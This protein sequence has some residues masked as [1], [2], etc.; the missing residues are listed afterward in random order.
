MMGSRILLF[1]P[2]IEAFISQECFLPAE[3]GLTGQVSFLEDCQNVSLFEDL[4]WPATYSQKLGIHP[5][6]CCPT[7]LPSEEENVTFANYDFEY[8]QESLV[9][10]SIPTMAD[11]NCSPYGEF[12][13]LPGIGNF[14]ECVSFHHCGK[15]I[16]SVDFP[17]SILTCGF[18]DST[19]NMMICCPKEYVSD[20]QQNKQKPRFPSASRARNC[21]DKHDLCEKW[22]ENGG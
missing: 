16:D 22:K 11:K 1:L 15:L 18:D 19:K 12:T 3:L 9:G 20:E 8:D 10:F 14:T 21:E 13:N 7:K 17:S 5:V 2:F 4:P 6:V